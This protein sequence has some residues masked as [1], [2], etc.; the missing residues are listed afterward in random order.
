MPP[1][2]PIL[3]L[4][5]LLLD[6]FGGAA[7]DLTDLDALVA[8]IN[9]FVAGMCDKAKGQVCRAKECCPECNTE[10]DDSIDCQLAGVAETM[11]SGMAG[12]QDALGMLG[13][14]LAAA[15]GETPAPTGE[16]DEQPAIPEFDT[17]CNVKEHTCTPSGDGGEDGSSTSS[18]SAAEGSSEA[19]HVGF[20]LAATV[21]IATTGMSV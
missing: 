6:P 2:P 15:T 8:Q 4:L 17:E 18:E 14:V 12:M 10:L 13:G 5:P 9:T 1:P 3:L 16:G 11:D 19:K 7:P 21:T 20:L